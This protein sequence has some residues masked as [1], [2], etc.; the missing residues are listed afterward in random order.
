[1]V[2]AAVCTKVAATYA[3][4]AEPVVALAEIAK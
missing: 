1:M 4:V 3:V 2:H